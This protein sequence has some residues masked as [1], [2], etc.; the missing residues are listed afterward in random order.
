MNCGCST[1]PENLASKIYSITCINF[2]A[3]LAVLPETLFQFWQFNTELS[4][5]HCILHINSRKVAFGLSM[6][7]CACGTLDPCRIPSDSAAIGGYIW[8][9]AL[10]W[11]PFKVTHVRPW[12][13]MTFL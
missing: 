6:Q 12:S 9:S 4:V 11:S 10:K 8:G 5:M 2:R 3:I 7:I 13:A 1:Q